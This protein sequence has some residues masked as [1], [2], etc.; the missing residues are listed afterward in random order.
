MHNICTQFHEKTFD[1]FNV[2]GRTR[3]PY[4]KV[5]RLQEWIQLPTLNYKGAQF[6]ES[7]S[8]NMVLVLCTLSND[9]LYLN[10]S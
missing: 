1:S 3:L 7:V 6:N 8:E 10:K 9:G 5:T 4:C 2:I